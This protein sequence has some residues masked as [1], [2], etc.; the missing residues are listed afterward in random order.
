MSNRYP[1]LR[2]TNKEKGGIEKDITE[3]VTVSWNRRQSSSLFCDRWVPLSSEGLVLKM[4]V[5]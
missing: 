4:L 3:G 2:A 1:N 5:R